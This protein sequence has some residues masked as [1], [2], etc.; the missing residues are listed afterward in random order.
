MIERNTLSFADAVCITPPVALK[1]GNVYP[2]VEMADVDPG[3]RNVRESQHREFKGGGSRFSSGDT[4]M[5]RITPCLEN[6]KIA[7]FRPS[8]EKAV[9]FGSTEF[10]VIRGRD[11]ITTNDYAYY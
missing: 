7:R 10:I 5:A 4:L 11:G 3:I 2:F 1:R 8:V 9:G 6:G